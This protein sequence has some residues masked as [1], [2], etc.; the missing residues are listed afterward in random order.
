LRSLERQGLVQVQTDADDARVRFATL[1]PKG[2]DELQEYDRRS[3]AYAEAVL[4]PLSEVQRVRLAA[5]MA[6]VEQLL[7]AAAVEIRVEPA[8]GAAAV[9]CLEQYARELTRRF[10]PVEGAGFEPSVPPIS[11]VVTP[12]AREAMRGHRACKLRCGGGS[13]QF[14]FRG[15]PFHRAGGVYGWVGLRFVALLGGFC[16]PTVQLKYTLG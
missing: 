9:S 8:D 15:E 7:R 6:N 13:A 3:D 2:K 10:P 16:L 14:I 1:T 4:A 5:A 12:H 11:S